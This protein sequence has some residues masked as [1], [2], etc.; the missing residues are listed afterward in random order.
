MLVWKWHLQD[1]QSLTD[2]VEWKI[3]IESNKEKKKWNY[4]G[5]KYSIWKTKGLC[6][7][8]VFYCQI[9][10]LKLKKLIIASKRKWKFLLINYYAKLKACG[11]YKIIIVIIC[12][13]K[14]SS[15]H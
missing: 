4:Y 15:T 14:I 10:C 1:L 8:C 5:K 11:Y 6:C 3:K 12:D 7:L 13:Y 9:Q 2:K